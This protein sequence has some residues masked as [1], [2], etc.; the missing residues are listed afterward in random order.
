MRNAEFGLRNGDQQKESRFDRRT[1]CESGKPYWPNEANSPQDQRGLDEAS[2][3]A[4][5]GVGGGSHHQRHDREGVLTLRFGEDIRVGRGTL[6]YGRVFDPT[7]PDG[8]VSDRVLPRGR[9]CVGS[10]PHSEF[11]STE[12]VAGRTPHSD[13]APL[14]VAAKRRTCCRPSTVYWLL[15][16]GYCLLIYPPINC[17][18]AVGIWLAMDS[19]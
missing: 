18:T 3:V 9:V 11:D 16:T 17:R 19:T 7:L 12:L 1:T 14:R 15:S 13:R 6:P 10:I 4:P 5:F 8:C 2:R